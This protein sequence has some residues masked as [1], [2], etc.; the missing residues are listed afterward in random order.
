MVRSLGADHV[1]AYNEEDFTRSDRRYDLM[2]DIAGS[3]SWP[4]CRRVLE[5]QATLVIVGGPKANR[6]FGPLSHVAKK[7]LAGLLSSRKVVF[8]IAK[9]NKPDMETLRELLESGK[10]KPVIDRRYELSEIADA[11]RYMGEGHCRAK[12]VLTV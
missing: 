5:P 12:V 2:L 8:F 4:A 1:I 11:L 7:F 6:L 9:F 10:V 3:R